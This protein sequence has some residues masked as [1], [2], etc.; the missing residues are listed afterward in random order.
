MSQT[1]LI[2]KMPNEIMW[3]FELEDDGTVL[4]S[5]CRSAEPDLFVFDTVGRNFFDS[6]FEFDD[7]L[8]FQ[9]HFRTFIKSH[10][11][12]ERL[13]CKCS[14]GKNQFDAKISMTRAFQT[15]YYNSTGVVMLEVKNS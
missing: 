13:T 3:L 4:H 8:T 2:E 11:A 15:G 7:I 1:N 10:K 6:T 12:A 5:S 14:Y 9:R